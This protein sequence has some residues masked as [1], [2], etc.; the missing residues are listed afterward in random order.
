M[1]DRV[2]IDS[3]APTVAS[4]MG[5]HRPHPE[6]RSGHEIEELATGDPPHVM[7]EIVLRG[8]DSDAFNAASWPHLWNAF[9]SA[10]TT[11]GELGST[12][13]DPAATIATIG[14]GGLPYQH[15]ITG[16]TLRNDTGGVTQAWGPGAPLSVIATLGDDIDHVTH[17]KARIGLVGT[18]TIDRGLIGGHWYIR[19]DHDDVTYAPDAKTEAARAIRTLKDGYGDDTTPDLLAVVFDGN[20][21]DADIAATE[22]LAGA[23]QLTTLTTGSVAF[24]LVG[25]G[26][27]VTGDN[28]AVQA[29][30]VTKLVEQG[31]PG[32]TPVVAATTPGGFFLDQKA[33]A[34]EEI[35]EDEVIRAIEDASVG[36]KPLFTDVFSSITVS[37]A[38]Y[39]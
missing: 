23:T 3:V 21:P 19:V 20:D 29:E 18:S 31:V 6:V 35:S 37:F 5:V 10:Q 11:T 24:A 16:T 34:K 36:S 4:I 39:C 14:T 22:V 13:E 27:G 17:Q 12:P 32:T 2:G 9:R 25:T 15:G 1:P 8:V 30:K 38:E 28:G 7:V 26:G 33:L